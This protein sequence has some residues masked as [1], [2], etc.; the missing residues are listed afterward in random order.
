MKWVLSELG[1]SG[2]RGVGGVGVGG[3]V[4]MYHRTVLRVISIRLGLNLTAHHGTAA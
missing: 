1:V 2:E 4:A 3:Q